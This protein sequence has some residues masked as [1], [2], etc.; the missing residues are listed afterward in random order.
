MLLCVGT[1]DTHMLALRGK[2]DMMKGNVC[3]P[4]DTH[5]KYIS[6]LKD[7]T[8]KTF[9]LESLSKCIHFYH[10]SIQKII[11]LVFYTQSNVVMLIFPMKNGGRVEV[12]IPPLLDHLVE[13]YSS[14]DSE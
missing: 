10:L 4:I 1:N 11:Q 9:S 6:C 2:T 7:F 3:I 14:S 8:N 12:V 13:R 5:T